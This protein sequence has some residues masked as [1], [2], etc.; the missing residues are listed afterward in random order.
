[1]DRS[2]QF[3]VWTLGYVALVTTLRNVYGEGFMRDWAIVIMVAWTL[4]FL[5]WLNRRKPGAS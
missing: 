4:P 2:L 3:A 5:W 1:M